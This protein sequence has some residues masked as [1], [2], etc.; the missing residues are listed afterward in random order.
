MNMS[1][2]Q[3]TTPFSMSARMVAQVERHSAPAQGSQ[4]L[5]FH[6]EGREFFKIWIVNLVLSV[7]T[8]G[9]YSAW[10]KVR[11][12]RYLH[13][14]TELAGARFEYH[15]SPRSILVGR[16][17][18]LL[19][20]G[21]AVVLG[22]S[23]NPLAFGF[24][25]AAA[26]LVPWLVANSMRFRAGVVSWRGVR[27]AWTGKT[28]KV[29]GTLLW[30]GFLTVI[31][32]GIYYFA[33]RHRIKRL[34]PDALH[35][36]DV[37][38]ESHST[39]GMFFGPHWYFFFVTGTGSKLLDVVAAQLQERWGPEVVNLVGAALAGWLVFVAYKLLEARL[40]QIIHNNTRI[41]NLHI[42]NTASFKELF[43]LYFFNALWTGLTLGMY[44]PWALVREMHYR[45]AHITVL[46]D[47]EQLHAHSTQAQ[48]QGAFGQEAAGLLDFDV[49]F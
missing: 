48:A 21:T 17:L 12:Q 34:L 33:A 47:V 37:P 23:G 44:W 11:T 4:S 45:M 39:A 9:I 7:L 26:A 6:G 20:G 10:A 28:S 25:L 38:F 2:F 13:A 32:F 29:Y 35:F 41:G 49:S 36:G 42:E 8:L 19:L 18:M 5:V 31:T 43:R 40:S 30:V 1:E 22:Q 3:N 15:A 24:L 16:T 14:N 27:F 46:G